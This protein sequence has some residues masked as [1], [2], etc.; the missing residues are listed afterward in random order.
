MTRTVA[1]LVLAMLLLPASGAVFVILFAAIL[2]PGAPPSVSRLLLLWAIVYLFIGVYWLLLWRTEVKWTAGRVAATAGGTA[3][4]LFAGV[5]MAALCLSL[6]RILPVQLL[7]LAGGGTVPIAWVLLTVIVWRETPA[8]RAGRL[9]AAGASDV[10]CPVCG[11]RMTGLREARCPE[12]GAAFTLEQLMA[13]QPA[14]AA[15]TAL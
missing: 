10:L 3:L 8:E 13:V 5:A 9:A 7:I 1:R 15:A 14:R 6:N 4:A 12:C 11:Y 2:R